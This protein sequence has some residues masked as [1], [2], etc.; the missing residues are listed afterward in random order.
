MS[1]FAFEGEIERYE[2]IMNSNNMPDKTLEEKFEQKCNQEM[3]WVGSLFM[4]QGDTKA[5]DIIMPT[6]ELLSATKNILALYSN[7]IAQQ[8]QEAADAAHN[9]PMGVSQWLAHGKKYGYD[10]FFIEEARQEAADEVRDAV[11]KRRKREF[12]EG[13]CDE[14]KTYMEGCEGCN[15]RAEDI[16]QTVSFNSGLDAAEK[17]ATQVA[18]DIN[19]NNQGE[20]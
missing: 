1:L 2:R 17:T 3:G 10:L 11:K 15:A 16:T 8:R 14:H 4:S 19:K 20:V 6:E 18:E 13:L 5:K 12:E 7:H 9:A